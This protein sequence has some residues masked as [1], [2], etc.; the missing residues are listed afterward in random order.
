M[1][2]LEKDKELRTGETPHHPVCIV[3]LY[4]SDPPSLSDPSYHVYMPRIS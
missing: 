3:N 2:E 1:P 4:S